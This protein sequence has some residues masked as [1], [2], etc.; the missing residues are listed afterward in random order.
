[1]RVQGVDQRERV[2]RDPAQEHRPRADDADAPRP[3]RPGRDRSVRMRT[4]SFALR[5]VGRSHAALFLSNPCLRATRHS[6]STANRH[7]PRSLPRSR[8]RVN[9]VTFIHPTPGRSLVRV[10]VRGPRGSARA[11]AGRRAASAASANASVGPSQRSS[12]T[13]AKSS[14]SVLSVARSLNSSA[15]SRLSPRISG[16]NSSIAPCRFRS[17]AAPTLPMPGNARVAVGRVADQRQEVGDQERVDAEL[18]AHAVL[19]PDGVRPAVD[20]HDPARA[21]A[22]GEILVGRPDPHL[23]DPR[24]LV[25]GPRRRRRARRRP[26]ARPSATPS[27]PSP[28]A[29]ARAARTGC[30]ARGRCPSPVL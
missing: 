25:G 20:L 23:L 9:A 27:R 17:R 28:R 8:E 15:S 2:V 5:L 26:R 29:R 12:S 3:A 11:G 22:L 14:V 4:R 10:S 18:L 7:F 30:A 19:V 24:V 21:H 6:E 1:M 13:S 16:G